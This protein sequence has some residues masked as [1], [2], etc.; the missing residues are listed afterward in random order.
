MFPDAQEE[1]ES[2]PTVGDFRGCRPIEGSSIDW[3]VPRAQV[4]STL[5]RARWVVQEFNSL[6]FMWRC[7]VEKGVQKKRRGQHFI[8]R[9]LQS[10][11]AS[12]HGRH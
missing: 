8:S 2:W 9:T 7:V 12:Y 3:A 6:A 10:T 1:G 4:V 11:L 5:A